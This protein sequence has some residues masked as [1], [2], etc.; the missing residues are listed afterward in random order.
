MCLAISLLIVNL[1]LLM[2][3]HLLIFISILCISSYSSAQSTWNTLTNQSPDYSAG[4]MILLTNGTV[5]CLTSDSSGMVSQDGN[6]W[7]LL[8]PDS[9]GSYLNGTWTQ[10]P[11]MHDTRLYCSSW[12]MPDGNVYVGGGEYGTGISTAELY[13]TTTQTWKY[14]TGMPANCE[15]YDGSCENLSDGTI[16]QGLVYN[17]S[18]QLTGNLLYNESKN[19][20]SVAASC[21]QAHDEVSWIKLPDGS[22]MSADAESI[23]SERYIPKLKKW[24]I[25]SNLHNYIMDRTVGETG[26]ALLLPNGKAFFFSDS[27]YTAIYTPS[28]DT[29]KGSWAQGPAMPVDSGVQLGCPD[30]P[31]AMMP[32]G[33]ILCAMGPA[34]SYKSPTYL[35]EY[36][37]L[38]NKFKQVSSP[39]GGDTIPGD[40]VF[41]N[42]MLVLPDG[43]ILYSIQGNTTFYQYVPSGSPIASGKPVIDNIIPSCPSFKITG[44]LFNG[45]SEGAAYGDDW[46][47]ATNYPIVRL[48]K[49]MHVYYATTS[50]WNRIGAVMTD[51]LEDTATFIIPPMP[52]GVYSVQVIANGIASSPYNLT[53]TCTAI[54]VM[55]IEPTDNTISV[56]PNPGKGIFTFE[57]SG[58]SKESSIEVYDMLGEKVYS[59]LNI[60]NSAFNIDLSDQPS[61]VY[62]YRVYINAHTLLGSGKL[63]LEK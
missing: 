21:F 19:S 30:A 42:N 15:I 20:F 24:I 61:G 17:S 11:P 43:T 8:T 18:Y 56:Y 32:N 57:S 60:T 58:L 22:I 48:T 51:S 10:L 29:N 12:I 53:L 5:M 28:G 52:T 7:D 35:F 63:I 44:K 55:D 13:N 6:T 3:K 9:T 37:Y 39:V 33:N 46:Q 31:A 16:L 41:A 54:G 59:I 27:T 2:K 23:T 45:I 14:V 50:N 36:N 1:L 38:S 40:P 62:Y 25:D 49:G 4:L 47:M 26:P 34:A